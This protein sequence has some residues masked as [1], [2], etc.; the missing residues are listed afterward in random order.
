MGEQVDPRRG[1]WLTRG[2]VVLRAVQLGVLGAVL[3]L[4]LAVNPEGTGLLFRTALG[5]KMLSAALALL[6]CG[7]LIHLLLCAGLNRLAPPGDESRRGT[8]RV[9]SCLLEGAHLVVFYLPAVC[10]LLVGPA[11]LS[12][13]ETMHAL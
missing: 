3:A 7:L 13:I 1:A 4:M 11:A 5:Q 2:Q 12:I 6:A 10:V 8:R 9:L